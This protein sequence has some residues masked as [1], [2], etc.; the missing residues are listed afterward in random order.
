MGMVHTFGQ[1]SECNTRIISEATSPQTGTK[2]GT[3]PAECFKYGT[4]Q[5]MF[6]LNPTAP[7]TARGQSSRFEMLQISA[8]TLPKVTML[9]H[10]KSMSVPLSIANKSKSTATSNHVMP[11]LANVLTLDDL[12]AW[13][14]CS[15]NAVT[16]AGERMKRVD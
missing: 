15:S 10:N 1:L 8:T 5:A 7:N 12:H 16:L 3:M 6:D 11:F 4:R 13:K 2:R 14:Y 9:G